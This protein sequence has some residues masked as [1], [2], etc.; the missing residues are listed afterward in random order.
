MTS[1]DCNTN[2]VPDECD[3][4]AGTSEDCNTNAVPDECDIAAGTSGDDNDNGVPNECD[5]IRAMGST[6]GSIVFFP[7][8]ELRFDPMGYMIGDTFITLS[9]DFNL[10]PGDVVRIDVAGRVLENPVG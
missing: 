6:K 1:D 10:S 2:V 9:N 5:P 8:V 4:A 7:K 3:I